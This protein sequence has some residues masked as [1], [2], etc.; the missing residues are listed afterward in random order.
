MI[1]FL[2][3]GALNWIAGRVEGVLSWLVALLTSTM[4]TTPDV[5]VFPQVQAVATARVGRS[6][7]PSAWQ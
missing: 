6:M 4:F 3:N 5:T 7:P 2:L 1:G